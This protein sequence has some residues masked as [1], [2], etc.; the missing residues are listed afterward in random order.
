MINKYTYTKKVQPNHYIPNALPYEPFEVSV[1]A[2]TFEEAE[3][4][5]Q[6]LIKKKLNDL[7]PKKTAEEKFVEELN[8]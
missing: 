7:M 4:E 2:D 5:V 3:A 6:R 8:N 1:E